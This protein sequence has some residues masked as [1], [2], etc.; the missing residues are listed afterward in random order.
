MSAE[1]WWARFTFTR[2]HLEALLEVNTQVLLARAQRDIDG[3][4]RDAERLSDAMERTVRETVQPPGYICL[5]LPISDRSSFPIL[6]L[7][8]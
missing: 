7:P 5:D 1:N 8:T 4:R 3:A 2:I 6:A